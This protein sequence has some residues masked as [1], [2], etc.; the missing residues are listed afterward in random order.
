MH[1][2]KISGIFSTNTIRKTILKTL[3]AIT[4]TSCTKQ[5]SRPPLKMQHTRFHLFVDLKKK[6]ARFVLTNKITRMFYKL[7]ISP[8]FLLAS[9]IRDEIAAKVW[10]WD[11]KIL[12]SRIIKIF[13]SH[14]ITKW[15][16]VSFH[17]NEN[18]L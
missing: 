11:I 13:F 14:I 16:I 5:S 15:D 8:S 7:F 10:P 12:F 2:A 6:T 9:R 3:T 17:A 4:L 18:G 1:I